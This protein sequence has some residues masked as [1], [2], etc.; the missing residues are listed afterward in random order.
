MDGLALDQWL[1]LRDVL[2]DQ[3]PSLR[4]RESA[5]FAWI[6]TITSVSGQ[7]I[8]AG[9]P[10]FYFPSSIHTTDREPP[11][12][13]QFWTDQ[14]TPAHT[15]GYAKGLG[16]GP[17][18]GVGGI[19]S[20]TDIRALGLVV[21]KVD[22]IMHGMELGAAGMHNQVRQW[23]GEGFMA[24]LLDQLLD[25]GF[26][27]YLTS[28]HGNIEAEGRGRP[29]EGA[30]ADI[31]GERARIYSD[32]VLRSRVHE[33]FP[34]RSHGPLSGF[35]TTTWPCS[36]RAG[37]R[38]FGKASASSGTAALPSKK[39]SSV[40]SDR[41]GDDVNRRDQ[42]GFSQRIHLDWLD[43]TANLVF[44]GNP[45]EE[46]VAA[47]RERL[48]EKL[49]VGSQPVRGNR[50]KAISILTKV[51][52]TVPRELRPLRDEG[53]DHLRARDPS[54]RLLVHWCMCMAV[55]PFF[56]TVADAVGRLL[57]LQEPPVPPK[58]NADSANA[59]ANAKPSSAPPAASSGPTSTGGYWRKQTRRASTAVPPNAPST[60]RHSPSGP[61]RP[62]YSPPATP[63]AR[64][65]PCSTAPTSSPSTSRSPQSGTSKPAKLWNS[66]ATASTRYPCLAS[67]SQPRSGI[68]SP[69]PSIAPTD[70]RQQTFD[71]NRSEWAPKS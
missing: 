68:D 6:P 59:T 70:S 55:Y 36:P 23:A 47:L 24:R 53:L 40:D 66:P 63:P 3:R 10:P 71:A 22:R 9:K 13:R 49:S 29:S 14:G 41:T 8:F 64:P 43:Y 45:K 54:D 1:V 17:G 33:Q 20:R 61:S 62:R 34:T 44:A 16:D 27:V 65:P 42:I 50:D 31:R 46:I 15:V 48:K 51:W 37:R 2:A 21:D 58:S 35:P 28:D 26:A 7:A 39:S 32:A 56:G 30:L 69:Q 18:D 25:D 67:R 52:V 4:F 11:S 12:W 60:T 57:R 19:L 5:V 38:S